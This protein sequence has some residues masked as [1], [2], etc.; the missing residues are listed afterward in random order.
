MIVAFMGADNIVAL[1]V[2]ST[3][4]C[5]SQMTIALRS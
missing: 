1:S 3:T 2:L 4:F 5:A